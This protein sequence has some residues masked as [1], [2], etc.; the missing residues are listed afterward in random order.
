MN[1][2]LLVLTLALVAGLALAPTAAADCPPTHAQ[3]CPLIPL[4]EGVG[5]LIDRT[6]D[7]AAEIA[8]DCL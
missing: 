8:R 7:L 5:C 4:G 2:A 3:A 6:G 1:K